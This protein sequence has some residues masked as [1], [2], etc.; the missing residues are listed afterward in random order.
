M[1]W[2]HQH[3]RW[4]SALSFTLLCGEGG[5]GCARCQLCRRVESLG[6][7]DLDHRSRSV[8]LRHKSLRHMPVH[9]QTKAREAEYDNGPYAHL[10]DDIMKG[11]AATAPAD[12]DVADVAKAIVSVV[13]FAL[14]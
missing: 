4:H 1:G 6:H 2:E 9:Q 13:E 7:R 3:S 5:Y 12:A 10:G 11:F 14:R 8:H